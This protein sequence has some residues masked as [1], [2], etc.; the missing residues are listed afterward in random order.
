[1]QINQNFENN[2][3]SWIT[4][5]CPFISFASNESIIICA[6]RSMINL[7]SLSQRQMFHVTLEHPKMKTYENNGYKSKVW[8][9]MQVHGF[10][11]MTRNTSSTITTWKG[12]ETHGHWHKNDF[13]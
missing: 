5:L 1:M 3:S 12:K 8:E 2:Y 10:F 11:T 7:T 13:F 9:C 4:I 6:K